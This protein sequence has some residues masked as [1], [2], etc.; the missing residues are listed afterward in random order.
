MLQLMRLTA[1]VSIVYVTLGAVGKTTTEARENPLPEATELACAGSDLTPQVQIALAELDYAEAVLISNGEIYYGSSSEQIL[2]DVAALPAYNDDDG[3]SAEEI[4][5][6]ELV[7]EY[8]RQLAY[9]QATE[10]LETQMNT[11][12]FG[13][14]VASAGQGI[15]LDVLAALRSNC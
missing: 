14:Q 13:I 3:V 10:K 9:A 11:M 7:L 15:T 4:L 5:A 6:L 12:P 1:L 8:G 2:A